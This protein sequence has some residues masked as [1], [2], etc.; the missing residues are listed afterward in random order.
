MRK[1]N[2]LKKLLGKGFL[3]FC[4]QLWATVSIWGGELYGQQHKIVT[5]ELKNVTLLD[6]L[7]YLTNVV[8]CEI[9]YNHEQVK[10]ERTFD[11]DMKEKTLEEVL[12]KCLEG[13]SLSYKIVDDVFVLTSGDDEKEKKEAREITGVVVSEQGDSI[14]GVTVLIKGTTLGTS[15]D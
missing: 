12:Q 4:I 2:R 1:N 8:G 7:E 9:L 3:I 5:V 6:A 14:P 11:L 10:S 13:T 15:T